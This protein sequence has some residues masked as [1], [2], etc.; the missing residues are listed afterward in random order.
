VNP[1]Q[2]YYEET[3][4]VFNIKDWKDENFKVGYNVYEGVGDG[5]KWALGLKLNSKRLS[6]KESFVHIINKEPVIVI[7][8]INDIGEAT[9][10][11]VRPWIVDR[12]DQIC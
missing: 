1:P 6:T 5:E 11:I 10:T 2:G 4:I 7:E 12:P 8:V 3:K 9:Y